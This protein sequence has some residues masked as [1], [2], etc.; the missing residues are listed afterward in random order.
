[1]RR[2]SPGFKKKKRKKKKKVPSRL[3]RFCALHNLLQT[4]CRL[5]ITETLF[6][7]QQ[8]LKTYGRVVNDGSGWRK[9]VVYQCLEFGQRA[10]EGKPPMR[11]TVGNGRPALRL[12][13]QE[14]VARLD[15]VWST[16]RVNGPLVRWG[17]RLSVW[18]GWMV[19]VEHEACE[20][21]FSSVGMHG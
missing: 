4:Y 12:V 1:M 9:D 2:I 14:C 13:T 11:T 17:C 6:V 3:K 8:F 18:P 21:T 16:R 15:G 5:N 19:C 10:D 7:S 20:W